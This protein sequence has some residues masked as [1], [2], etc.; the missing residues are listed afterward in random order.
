MKTSSFR[1][2]SSVILAIVFSSP[3]LAQLIGDPRSVEDPTDAAID[4]ESGNGNSESTDAITADDQLSTLPPEFLDP[5]FDRYVDLVHLG[6]ALRHAD[7]DRVVNAALQLAEGE[8]ILLRAHKSGVTAKALIAKASKFAADSGNQ[9]ALSRL[10]TAAQ[11]LQDNELLAQIE[12]K[13][14]LA[15]SS[16]TSDPV[17]TVSV[18]TTDVDTLAEL[19]GWL[20]VVRTAASLGDRPALELLKETLPQ[21]GR[22]SQEQQDAIMK[23]IDQALDDTSDLSPGDALLQVLAG[24]S[25]ADS[26]RQA[27]RNRIEGG[28]WN[29]VWGKTV[30]AREYAE[31]VATTASGT[32]GAYFGYLLEANI[33]KMQRQLPGVS[34]RVLM[35]AV[36]RAIQGKQVVR[37]GRMG[38]KGG[39]ATY[40]YWN[41]VTVQVP[42]GTERYKI[43]GPFGSRTWGY[44]P[45][46]KTVTKTVPAEPNN[47]QPY[48]GFRVY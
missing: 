16:R 1:I 21:T 46:Y 36:T 22:M 18:E 15:A 4:G 8:R 6:D 45:K 10:S 19:K 35:D 44:R 32:L 34:K 3:S 28:G 43:K 48:F 27:V 12:A 13:R 33:E 38:I 23:R 7:T 24:A 9:D 37:I 2:A 11:K 5:A 40:R 25:R 26:D 39:I 14:K 20:D 17:L 29:I 42:D 30:A 47:H 31:L 41:T